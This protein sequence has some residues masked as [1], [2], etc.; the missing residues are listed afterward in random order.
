MT[1]RIEPEAITYEPITQGLPREIGSWLRRNSV[2][3]CANQVR[4][5][6]SFGTWFVDSAYS[7]TVPQ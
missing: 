4:D 2:N 5:A 6:A 1:A 3:Y 7:T